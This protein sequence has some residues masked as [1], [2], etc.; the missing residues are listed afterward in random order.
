MDAMKTIVL[1]SETLVLIRENEPP[2]AVEPASG[3]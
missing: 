2:A 3:N 1:L